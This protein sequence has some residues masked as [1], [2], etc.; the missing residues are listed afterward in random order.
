M[1][2]KLENYLI[3]TFPQLYN[4][5]FSFDCG[6]GWFRLI[7]WLNRYLHDYIDDQNKLASKNQDFKPVEQIKILRIKE[8]WGV[9]KIYT[10]GGN[11]HIS[12][13]LNFV[14]Y[15]SGFIC[16]H[17]GKTSD[18]GFNEYGCIKTHHS[19]ISNKN[20]FNYVDD[21]ELRVILSNVDLKF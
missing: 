10:S 4:E 13:I 21:E 11:D 3:K 18:V 8:K 16:E 20:D 5:N 6:N 9:L 2:S 1:D 12:S 7:L 15:I 17:T 19:S 14:S